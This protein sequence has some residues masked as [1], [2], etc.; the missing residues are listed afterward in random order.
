MIRASFTFV[1]GSNAEEAD[2]LRVQVRSGDGRK[3]ASPLSS[4]FST[5]DESGES[6]DFGSALSSSLSTSRAT[7]LGLERQTNRT[8]FHYNN[9]TSQY[10][11]CI[12]T[13]A[14]LHPVGFCFHLENG[15]LCCCVI[16]G[17][18]A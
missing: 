4:L 15:T 2:W 14:Q 8:A 18:P 6:G 7:R 16:F 11:G 5:S 12:M 17:T 9:H 1:L 3:A 13:K 10:H